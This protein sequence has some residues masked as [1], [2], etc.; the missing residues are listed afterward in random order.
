MRLPPRWLR[1]IILW[2]LPLLAVFVYV[3]TVPLLVVAALILSYR[4]PGRWRALRLLGLAT[5]YLFVE[6]AVSIVAL[7]L[8]LASGCGWKLDSNAFTTAH[9][10]LLRWALALL[11]FTARRLFSLDVERDGR[12][13]PSDDG[14]DSTT[15]VPLIVLGRHAGPADSFLLLHEVMSWKGRRP[16]IVAKA[17]LQFDPAFD[18]LLN[19]LPNRFIDAN[20]SPGGGTTAMVADLATGMTNVDAFVI[21][22]EGGNFTEA[23]RTR[24]IERLRSDGHHA[25]AQRASSM[26]HVLP[27]RP[28]GTLAAIDA[29]PEADVVFVAHTG[30]DQIVTVSDLWSSIPEHKTLELAWRVLAADD[31][32]ADHDGRVDMLLRAWERIDEWI[33]ERRDP[34]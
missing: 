29:C 33:D 10:R 34:T 28:A 23:R 32:P 25:A 1:R 30:L 2:P 22:P 27:P 5:C 6:A 20:P 26:T 17:A 15:E 11:V 14:D 16:R 19:R 31:V 13:L 7:A 18:I 24:A 21:F 9:H 12:P 4:L 8:W 3:T